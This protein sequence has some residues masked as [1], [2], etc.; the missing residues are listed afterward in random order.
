[1]RKKWISIALTACV[2]GLLSYRAQASEETSGN[3]EIE[4]LR[5]RYEAYQQSFEIGRASCRERV[6][7]NV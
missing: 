6:S 3:G 7:V 1:M 2:C 4:E 5:E